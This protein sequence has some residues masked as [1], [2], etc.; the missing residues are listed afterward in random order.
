MRTVLGTHFNFTQKIVHNFQ[1][2]FIQ[3]NRTIFSSYFYADKSDDFIGTPILISRKNNAQFSVLIYTDK[4]DDFIGKK[5][6]PNAPLC[7][8]FHRIKKAIPLNEMEYG[9][10]LKTIECGELKSVHEVLENSLLS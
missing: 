6:A 7:H 9:M 2:I 8:Y 5:I 10:L 4:S 3:T 1:F